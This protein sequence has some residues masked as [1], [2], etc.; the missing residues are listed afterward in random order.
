MDDITQSRTASVLTLLLGAWLVVSPLFIS[1]TG[2]ALV[3]LF[4]V[5]G[6]M[7]LSGFAQLLTD[8]SLP[9]W[10]TGVAAVY[11]V[12]SAFIF[13]VSNNVIWNEVVA[14]IVGFLLAAWDGIEVTQIHDRHHHAGT[15]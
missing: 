8:N 2:A 6:V 9:S 10:I 3:S 5:G 7:I 11:L 15:M 1:I 4:I 13:D 12:A 14:G